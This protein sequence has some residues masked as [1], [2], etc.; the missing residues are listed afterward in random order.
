MENSTQ[1]VSKNH[2][3]F[4][5]LLPTWV[6]V[7]GLG[8]NV[9]SSWALVGGYEGKVGSNLEVWKVFWGLV[10]RGRGRQFLK[11]HLPKATTKPWVGTSAALEAIYRRFYS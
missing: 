10:G 7:G 9:G 4:S 11:K 6:Q 3:K 8:S 5:N 2:P 1:L